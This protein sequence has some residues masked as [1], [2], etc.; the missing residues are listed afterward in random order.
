MRC[1]ALVIVVLMAVVPAVY[2]VEV[3]STASVETFRTDLHTTMVSPNLYFKL[4]RIEG[5]GFIDRYLEDP[6]FY[7]GEFMLTFQPLTVQPLD[8]ISIIVERRWDKFADDENS[9]G[10]RIKLW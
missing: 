9:Y 6:E 1:A 3:F 10:I 2:P 5:Y 4:W 8:R 7:H